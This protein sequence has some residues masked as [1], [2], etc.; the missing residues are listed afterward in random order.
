M[1]QRQ[2]L[3][4]EKGNKFS[5]RWKQRVGQLQNPFPLPSPEWCVKIAQW[6]AEKCLIDFILYPCIKEKQHC[7]SNDENLQSCRYLTFHWMTPWQVGHLHFKY[8]R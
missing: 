1:G 7:F 5:H 3:K 4:K 8:M 6:V 2:F